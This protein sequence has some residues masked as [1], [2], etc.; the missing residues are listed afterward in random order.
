MVRMLRVAVMSVVGSPSTSRRSARSPG[1]M[2]P[3]SVRAKQSAGTEV[4][5]ARASAGVRPASTRSSTSRSLPYRPKLSS[6]AELMT[7]LELSPWAGASYN[8]EQ[9][10]ANMRTHPFGS[11]GEGFIIYLVLELER[12][13]SILRVVWLG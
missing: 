9:P 1:V 6:F 10:D 11:A 7:L 12:R 13:V 4:A 5:A 3:R 2:R 8:R